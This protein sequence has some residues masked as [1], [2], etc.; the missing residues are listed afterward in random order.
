VNISNAGPPGFRSI[1]ADRPRNDSV[2]I[3]PAYNEAGN[4]EPLARQVLALGIFDMLV[5]DD[6]SPDG[7]GAVADELA[8]H[9][10][11]RVVVLHRPGKLGLASA[12][13]QGFTYALAAGYERILQMDADFSHD[14]GRL[15]AL[16]DALDHA[17]VALGSRYA[18]G[19][20][21]RH[22]PLRRRILSRAGSAYAAAVLGL[23]LRDVTSGF[24]GFARRALQALDFDAICSTGYSFQIEVTYRCHQQGIRIAEV[25]IT[26]EDRRVGESKMSGHIIAEALL[27][28]WRL[29]FDRMQR[30]RMLPWSGAI[31]EGENEPERLAHQLN[32][33][34]EPDAAK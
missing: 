23:P 1:D 20:S 3:I 18:S 27:M 12:Y 29:R 26:F 2:V 30:G 8:A 5:V 31:C 22:W 10:P 34:Q 14:P 9:F 17:E 16:R 33:G 24:K 4:L 19:G 11:G 32:V 13:V 28:V 21:T 6:H 25:P 7:T 15:P